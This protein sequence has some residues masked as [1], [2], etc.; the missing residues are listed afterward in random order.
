M[1]ELAPACVAV[2]VARVPQRTR[3]V[4]QIERKG[5][6]AALFVAFCAAL[7]GVAIWRLNRG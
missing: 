7:A 1:S 2:E 3:V 4:L 5:S 6:P